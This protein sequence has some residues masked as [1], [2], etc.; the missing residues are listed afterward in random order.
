MQNIQTV[1]QV[2]SRFAAALPI[3]VGSEAFRRAAFGD[4]HPLKIIRHSAVTDLA[5][6]LGWLPDE[7]FRACEPA[8]VERLLEF[9]DRAYVKALRHADATGRVERDVR[10]RYQIGTMENPLFDG[11]FD[12]AART[13]G[14]SILAAELAL[15]GHTVFH[16][17]GGTHH[18]RADR[19]CGFCYFNDPVFAIRTFLDAGI[20]QVLYVDLDA[21]HGDGVE[22]A[23]F[24]ESR[25]TTLSVHEDYRWPYSGTMSYPKEKAFNLPVPRGFNDSELDY[26]IDNAVL[27]LAEGV[28]AQALV[29]CCGADCLAGD[30]LSTMVLSNVALWRAVDELLALGL[31]TVVVGGGGYNPW[32]VTRYW[33]GLWGRIS[34][35]PIPETL[36]QQAVELL[37]GMECDLVDED[38]IDARWY[39]TLADTPNPGPVRDSVKSLADSIEGYSL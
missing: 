5:R 14:G 20:E 8:T 4:N 15:E 36:P 32:T 30:P 10:E 3:F 38:D 9:H 17:S 18:G 23:F 2:E 31:P 22:I 26:V 33:A 7:H 6:I 29:V 35:Q 27:P 16:P 11:V 13:V 24:D 37:H 21:H 34:G 19:A 25:V 1:N 28:R 39:N 12:R